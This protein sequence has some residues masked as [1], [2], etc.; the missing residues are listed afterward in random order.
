[1]QRKN[2]ALLLK[3]FQYKRVHRQG[4]SY[5]LGLPIAWL[6]LNADLIGGDYWV[7]IES[8]TDGSLVIKAL[9]KDEAFSYLD[10]NEDNLEDSTVQP[11]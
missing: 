11:D 1:M 6:R 10:V 8:E 7:T 3:S 2:L 9:T 5:L 4:G